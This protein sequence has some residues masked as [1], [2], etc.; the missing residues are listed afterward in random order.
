MG[1]LA[2][3]DQRHE[4]RERITDL[5]AEATIVYGYPDDL[6]IVSGDAEKGAVINSVLL[7]CEQPK[8]CEATHAVEAFGPVSTIIPNESVDDSIHLA[9]CGGGS[10]VALVFTDE[11]NLPVMML[12]GLHPGLDVSC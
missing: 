5:C 8:G 9:S 12:L 1:P 10:L 2:S 6:N 7:Y 4:M 11:G 3:L